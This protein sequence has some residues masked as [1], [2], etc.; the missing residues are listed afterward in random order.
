ML[1][2]DSAAD[3]SSPPPGH[4]WLGSFDWLVTPCQL[5]VSGLAAGGASSSGSLVVSQHWR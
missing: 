3:F 4:M 2:S 5:Q 1:S